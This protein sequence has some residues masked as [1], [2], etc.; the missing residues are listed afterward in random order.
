M[1]SGFSTGDPHLCALSNQP[2]LRL[3]LYP[4][5]GPF[6]SRLRKS[7]FTDTFVPAPFAHSKKIRFSRR[8]FFPGSIV[9][10]R[11]R[12]KGNLLVINKFLK[13]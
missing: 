4:P 3:F 10:I 7:V 13:G 12:A 1:E 5:A 2:P 6:S 8:Y 9:L 11:G